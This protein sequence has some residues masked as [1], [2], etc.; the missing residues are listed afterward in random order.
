M[1]KDGKDKES[2]DT[3]VS[4]LAKSFVENKKNEDSSLSFTLSKYS[5]KDISELKY[6][7]KSKDLSVHIEVNEHNPNDLDV[8]FNGD[9]R[10]IK[11]LLNYF[12][13]KKEKELINYYNLRVKLKYSNLLK[14]NRKKQSEYFKLRIKLVG[15][16]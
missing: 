8:A 11:S 4:F 7:A 3:I 10:A 14:T 5:E 12:K 1:K 6:L 2:A 16:R 9:V 13:L 15:A